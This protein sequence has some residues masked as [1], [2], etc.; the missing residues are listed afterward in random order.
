MT[1]IDPSYSQDPA[2]AVGLPK[3]DFL[4]IR[5]LSILEDSVRLAKR[6]QNV[7]IDIEN[8]PLDDKKTFDLLAKGET[9]GLFQLNGSGMTKYLKDLRPS[10]I[11]DINTMV[12]LYRPGPID[13]IPEYIRRKHDPRLVTYLDP[14]MKDILGTSYGVIVYQEDVMLTAINLAGYSWLEADTLRKA[15]GKKIPAEMAAQKEK[16][17]KGLIERGMSREKTQKL[18]SL[19]EPFAAYG[20]NKSHAACYGRV[21]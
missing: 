7:D 21:A 6:Y 3:V 5:N 20:F 9:M 10:S 4:G 13:S 2:L 14:R 8:I 19:I 15:M 11:H 12:A 16:L 17:S 1:S 18:W